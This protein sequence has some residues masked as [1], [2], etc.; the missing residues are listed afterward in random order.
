MSFIDDAWNA[1]LP[2]REK[3]FAFVDHVVAVIG[4]AALGGCLMG[5]VIVQ[6][7]SSM[8]PSRSEETLRLLSLMQQD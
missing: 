3:E 7:I 5:A 4:I 2:S 6:L 1:I 8:P